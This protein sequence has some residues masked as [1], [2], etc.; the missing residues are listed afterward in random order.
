MFFLY[1]FNIYLHVKMLK[2]AIDCALCFGFLYFL[3]IFA[4][5]VCLFGP[6]DAEGGREDEPWLIHLT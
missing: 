3:C 1:K 5:A 6:W 2:R 4:M